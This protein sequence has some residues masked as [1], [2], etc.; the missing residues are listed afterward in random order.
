MNV[1][2]RDGLAREFS[3]VLRAGG[4]LVFFDILAGDAAAPLI[5]PLPWATTP[6]T[7]FLQTLAQTTATLERAGLRLERWNDLTDR[8]IAAMSAQLGAPRPPVSLM[9]VMG[10]RIGAM[11][12][13]L[14][15]NARHGNLRAVM[16]RATRG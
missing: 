13:N 1:A 14:V 9:T 11:A 6:Q 10:D 8:A 5:F 4:R 16:G 7:S 2:D 15:E 3:R 12:M